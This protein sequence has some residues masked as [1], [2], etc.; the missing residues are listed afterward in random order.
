MKKY[1]LWDR[2]GFAWNGVRLAFSQEQ[3]FRI[4][5]LSGVG[6]FLFLALIRPSLIWWAVVVLTIGGVLSAEMMNTALERVLDRL[7]PNEDP[8]IA[9]AKDCAA[10]AVLVLSIASVVIL[11][12]LILF[13]LG[14]V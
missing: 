3:N 10:G 2:V 11:V 1:T 4:Q 13:A 7:H 5:V 8:L 12:A 14:V 6:A 9:Q